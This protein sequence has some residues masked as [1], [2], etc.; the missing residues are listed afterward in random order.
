MIR[1][2]WMIKDVE[3]LCAHM[4]AQASFAVLAALK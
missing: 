2:K 1:N 3:A 4:A